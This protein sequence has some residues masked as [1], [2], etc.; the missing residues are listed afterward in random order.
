MHNRDALIDTR[1]RCVGSE[2]SAADCKTISARGI[3][4]EA[5][6]ISGTRRHNK[7][8][9]HQRERG[10][11][12]GIRNGPKEVTLPSFLLSNVRS[13]E[14]GMEMRLGLTWTGDCCVRIFTGAWLTPSDGAVCLFGANRTQDSG[15]HR[16]QLCVHMN[17]ALCSGVVEV[18]G[19]R[20]QVLSFWC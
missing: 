10:K 1:K 16:G 4:R 8:C 12:G 15:K 3:C 20:L 19:G 9:A 11:R 18:D 5:S 2:L 13:R 17:N 7:R 14:G 6:Q